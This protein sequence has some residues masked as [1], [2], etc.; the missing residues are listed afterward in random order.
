MPGFNLRKHLKAYVKYNKFTRLIVPGSLIFRESPPR[1]GGIWEEVDTVK[2]CPFKGDGACSGSPWIN[3]Y[4]PWDYAP[5]A[6]RLDSNCNA[7]FYQQEFSGKISC[8][9]FNAIGDLVW[10]REYD[11][12]Q[13]NVYIGNGVNINIDPSDYVYAC[14]DN[15]IVKLDPLNGDV[16]WYK[17]WGENS[18]IYASGV[19]FDYNGN[20]FISGQAPNNTYHV[21]KLDANTGDFIDEVQF[22]PYPSTITTSY[23]AY[24]SDIDVNGNIYFPT[25]MSESGNGYCG[26]VFK[27][28]NDLNFV[29]AKVADPTIFT[30]DTDI[31][32]FGTDLEGNSYVSGY[33]HLLYRISTDGS[34]PWA[35]TMDTAAGSTDIYMSQFAFN[36]RTGDVFWISCDNQNL[37]DP[38]GSSDVMV[39]VLKFDKDG[40]YLWAT[41]ISQ[42]AG[43]EV[44]VD[45]FE[46]NTSTNGSNDTIL[47]GGY[48]QEDGASIEGSSAFIK[49]SALEQTIGTFG[50][51]TFRDVTDLFI[52]VLF[53]V[54]SIDAP[55][56]ILSSSVFNDSN[57]YPVATYSE[58]VPSLTITKIPLT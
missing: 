35:Y 47:M 17:F 31:I 49:M 11:F 16:I 7:Y 2:C 4:E 26:P 22:K 33:G 27:F 53:A 40:N 37:W 52:P 13:P 54:P 34:I 10:Q 5:I 14:T 58:T 29:S 42:P 50:N 25:A 21:G 9:K 45:W 8:W 18:S 57:L 6:G 39:A 3:D 1:D 12:I 32:G 15:G 55:Y 30:T 51:Y 38:D 36:K 24:G 41:E 43:G 44:S 20:L 48:V 23:L 19:V 28:D 46:M 56:S